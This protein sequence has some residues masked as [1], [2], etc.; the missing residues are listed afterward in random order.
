MDDR[1]DRVASLANIASYDAAGA[2]SY[3]DGAP[4]IK[5]ASLRQLYGELVVMV[6]DRARERVTVPHILDLGAGEGSV[7]L[8]FLEL[9]A[10]V[11]AVDISSSQ[12]ERLRGKCGAFG[13][14]LRVRC[15]DIHDVL[16]ERDERYDVIV[17]NS[18]MHHIPDYLGMIDEAIGLLSPAGQFFS[19][20]DPMRYDSF[21]RFSTAFINIAYF[22]WR[23]F[24]GDLLGGIQ[25]RLRRRRGEYLEDAVEDQ[26][27]YHAL[28]GGLDHD[29][30]GRLFA[31]RG[32]GC[33]LITY[34]S[35]QSGLFQ[36]I[37]AALG[38]KNTFSIIAGRREASA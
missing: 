32:F 3:I 20:Q 11:T 19:F 1:I 35:T 9:G 24:K 25:R 36:P 30:I 28:R 22:S 26:T 12:L 6:Y 31:E 33:E 15:E 5:H 17:A 16:K 18:F 10:K 23:I 14:S 37:G 8:P 29:A 7:T 38:I 27:E 34:F 2:A 4:H 21:G 13:D